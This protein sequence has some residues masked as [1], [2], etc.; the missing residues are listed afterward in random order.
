MI[1]RVSPI[2]ISSSML[3]ELSLSVSTCPSVGASQGLN[4]RVL[5]LCIDAH[6]FGNLILSHC[7]KNHPYAA[8][9][10]FICKSSELQTHFLFNISAN[11]PIQFNVHEP[12]L[13]SLTN[14]SSAFPLFPISSTPRRS[15][16]MLNI[17]Y[18]DLLCLSTLKSSTKSGQHDSRIMSSFSTSATAILIQTS[19]VS[20][21]LL[22]GNKLPKLSIHLTCPTSFVYAS[23]IIQSGLTDTQ[24][25][26]CHPLYQVLQRLSIIFRIKFQ[27]YVMIQE[28]LRDLAPTELPASVLTALFPS[29]SPPWRSPPGQVCFW[30]KVL[31]AYFSAPE[32]FF[33]RCL[34]GLFS[35]FIWDFVQITSFPERPYLTIRFRIALDLYHI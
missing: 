6:A 18:P 4:L 9:P 21:S 26:P 2:S 30:F 19:T 27:V 32:A 29:S 35:H 12:N 16:Q 20:L 10:D 22:V 28:P 13:T 8:D 31:H 33:L 14:K 1:S 3:I 5:C 11:R 24:I 17:H 7:F 23:Y 25:R 15:I 34:H